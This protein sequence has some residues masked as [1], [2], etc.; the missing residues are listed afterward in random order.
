MGS[1]SGLVALFEQGMNVGE[2][3]RFALC[4]HEHVR[5]LK[6]ERAGIDEYDGLGPMPDRAAWSTAPTID[7]AA[8]RPCGSVLCLA[9]GYLIKLRMASRRATRD[10]LFGCFGI[11]IGI[12]FVRS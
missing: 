10:G 7:A 3:L 8:A 12:G 5:G 4:R 1:A 11:G 2:Q 9:L 6:A